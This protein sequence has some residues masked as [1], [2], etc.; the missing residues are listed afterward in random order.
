MKIRLYI[1]FLL[2]LLLGIGTLAAQNSNRLYIP[3]L[4]A[5]PG[6]TLS[7]PVY[8]ENSVEIVAVQFALQVPEGSTLTTASAA[9]ANR[10]DDHTVTLRATA[11]REYLCVIYSPT[12]SPIKGRTG[13]IMTVDMQVGSN[14]KEGNTY[15]F[16][17][18]DVIL[19]MRDGSNV[20]S[21]SEAGALTVAKRPDLSIKNVKADKTA[22][23][24]SETLSVSWQVQNVGGV[25]TGDGWSEQI[26]LVKTD[27][28]S[29]LLGTA[30]YDDTLSPSGIVSRQVTVT[31]PQVL[32]LD[33]NAK[34]QVQV[35]PRTGTGE[36]E[37][38]RGNNTAT[39]T[40]SVNVG[41]QL[42]LA[43]PTGSIV[44]NY[45]SPIRCTL[46]R[47][48]NR[49]QEQTFT[50]SSTADS[51][52]TIPQEVTIP[53]GQSAA[54]F[55]I[56]IK[57]NTTL[58]NSGL[59]N[60]TAMGNGY[61]AVSGQ[62]TIED[63]EYP[64]LKLV[65]S[66]SQ[67]TE[68]ES[69]QLT[70]TAS[71]VS[72]NPV[73]V[74]LTSENTN[75]FSFPTTVTIPSGKKSVQVAVQ[76]VDDELP[77]LDLSNAFTASAPGYNKGEVIVILK[78]N[79]LPV[80]ELTLTPAIVS[81]SAGVVAVAG[82]LK[83][84]TNTTS[85]IT[86]KLSDDA[87]GGLYFG[88]RTLEL[89][90]GVEEA[91]FNFGP[92]DN[93]LVDGDR[94]YTITAAVWLSSCSC[95]ASGE[96]AG[97]V[98]AQLQ[99]L[100]NDGAALSLTSSQSTVKEGGKTTL[101]VTRNTTDNTKP[102]TVTLQSDYDDNLTYNHTVTIPA[103]KTSATVEVTSKGNDIQGDSHTVVFTVQAN[104]Y[105]TGTCYLM[106][107]DQTLPD[108]RISSIT[109]DVTEAEV[110]TKV[111]LGI[112][113]ANDGAAV[114]P[115]EVPVKLYFRGDANAVGTIYTSEAI[116]VGG[117]QVL[118]KTITLP[119]TVGN[120]NY[121]AVVNETNKVQELTYNN[122]TSAD[123]AIATIAPFSASISTDKSVYS[124]GE[125]V[126]I[127]GQLTGNGTEN[128]SVDIYLINEGARQVQNVT[129]DANGS[130][131]YEWQLY[132][133]QSGHFSVGACYPG[134]GM[135]EEMASFDVYGLKRTDNGYITCEILVGETYNGTIEVE[136][137]CS[138]K[139]EDVH[140]ELLSEPSDCMISFEPIGKFEGGE[141][142]VLKYQIKGLAASD[143]NDWKTINA[144]MISNSGSSM[145]LTLYYYCR[146]PQAQLDAGISRIETTVVQ[147]S[148]REYPIT[149]TNRG[150]GESGQITLALPSFMSVQSAQPIPSLLPNESTTIML[151]LS[152]TDNMQLNVPVSNYI[153][154]NCENSNGVALPY[155]IVPVSESNGE[156]LVDVCD[157]YTYYT[158]EKPHVAGATL[159]IKR[160]LT[161]EVLY[162]GITESDGKY[163][164]ILP[165]G[166]YSLSV[167]ADK[168]ESYES[169][170]LIDPGRRNSIV[171][172]LS[173]EGGVSVNWDVVETEIEDEYTIS[174]T[175]T[176]ETN[177]P[178]P[179]MDLNIPNSIPANDLGIGESLIF[180]AT[181]TN[182]GL[183][184][185]H[186]AQIILPEDSPGLVFE[187]LQGA[188]VDLSAQQSIVIP[189]KVTRVD[190]S[191]S[192]R[193]RANRE[194][195]IHCV[196]VIIPTGYWDCGPDRKWYRRGGQSINLGIV[197][198]SIELSGDFGERSELPLY[199]RLSGANFN[200]YI[201]NI[202]EIFPP[203]NIK[204]DGCFPCLQSRVFDCVAGIIPFYDCI[205]VGDDCHDAQ[206]NKTGGW[207]SKTNCLLSATGC[208]LDV[209]A[210]ESLKTIV[211]TPVSAACE[212]AGI[213]IDII[214]CLVNLTE[215]C[216]LGEAP[217]SSRRKSSYE[218]PSFITA[219]REAAGVA[220]KEV[221]GFTDVMLEYFGDSVWVKNTTIE[222]QFEILT[223]F[224]VNTDEYFTI[225]GLSNY[226]PEGI[227]ESQLAML[228]ERLNNSTRYEQTGEESNNRI[229]QEFIDEGW[230]KVDEAEKEAI[231]MGYASVDEMF[232]IVFEDS[233]KKIVEKNSAV[234]ATISLQLDQTMTLTRQ[235]FRGTLT[236]YN[237]NEDTPMQDVKLNLK[238]TNMSTGEVSTSHEFQIN[239]E[240]L[241]GFSGELDLGS[242]WTLG[243][244][245]TG[246][247]TILFIPTKY[248]APTEPVEWSF[249]G[250]LNYID[251]FT[252]LEVTREL[253]PVTLTV[254]PTPELDLTYFMQRDVY[255]DDPLTEEV[256]P[257]VPAE[258]SLLINNIGNGDATNV[259]MMTNQPEI[260]EN[261]KGLAINFEILSAQLNGGD[262]TMALGGSVATDFG[263]IPAHSQA[264]AQ[265]WLQ[266]SL[267]GHFTEYDVRATH[268]TSY[269]N[270]DLSLLNDVTIHELIRSIKV[271]DG[272]VTGF[273]VND[274][275]DAEDMPDMVYFTDG[276]TAE[277]AA[278]A[279]ASCDR[280]SNTEFLLNVT[281]SQAGWNY[282]HVTDPTFGRSRLTGIRRQSDGK[283]INLRNFWQTDRTL[284]DGKEW[285][286]ENNLHFVDQMANSTETYVLTFEP[287]P[288][289]ELQV[290]SFGGVPE[291]NVVLHEPLQ[292]VTVTFNKAVNA[293]TFTSEDISLHCQG[294]PVEG[295]IGIKKVNDKQFKLDM[296]QLTVGNGYY[297]L[298]VQTAGITD[299]EGFNG[300][301]GKT[302]AWIQFTEPT[303]LALSFYEAE[304]T[305]GDNFTEPRLQ[306][307]NSLA[308]PSY[309]STNPLVASVNAETGHVTINAVGTTEVNVSV[310]KTAMSDAAQTSYSLTVLQPESF[311]EVPAGVETVSITIPEGQSM[312]TFCSPW[313][314]DFRGSKNNCKAY[315]AVTY[316]D[317]IVV[318]KEVNEVDGGVGLLI[319]GIPGTYTFPVSPTFHVPAENLFV[320]TLAPTYVDETTGDKTNLSLLA[321][322]FVPMS[323][324]VIGA[325]KA[326]LP[327][328]LDD[329]V[330]AMNIAL[331]SLT[332]LSVIT[333][334]PGDGAWY[335]VSGMKM[336]RPA[337]KGIYI[338]NGRK[339]IV[340]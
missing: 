175:I 164:Q 322:R 273:V 198:T 18:K 210:V 54:S 305:Y 63:N 297:V 105:A 190:F 275:V 69:F 288:D 39:T 263:T 182:R 5:L 58:D 236:V 36:S 231:A 16:V 103:G 254:K 153:G 132:A 79:D 234:C 158:D 45:A 319:I 178:V 260:I 119:Q 27:G 179:I 21:S 73:E 300:A 336:N 280:R 187:S 136:N 213:I 232:Q 283:E 95:G 96:S 43:L 8:V 144:R 7:V 145:P 52:L 314:I 205:S 23:A 308:V 329:G 77:S 307:N 227:T 9:L 207:R 206:T 212:T 253:F 115:A 149:I 225:G 24:P 51:R 172:N 284:R 216:N 61:D 196:E 33:G 224:A 228:V 261:E 276:T 312:I 310:E 99:V 199:G 270:P 287:R 316:R 140:V 302:A 243:A 183:I 131:Y 223:E 143:G 64:D 203:I 291:E 41:K 185:I 38:V 248:A 303:T 49:A 333:E 274:L 265:W 118:T 306:T 323:A 272:N 298:T 138:I 335:S 246:T 315:T 299:S 250:T 313:P 169:N 188:P 292:S 130:F 255:G 80:L 157:E 163:L 180:Y 156:L 84:T 108:A 160:L 56:Q 268:V 282:G 279:N 48:G 269:D 93:A 120:H 126:I 184:T 26:S 71:R 75:R 238:V 117:S 338:R 110:G 114:L 311:S 193:R 295:S 107:T 78:D 293:S 317:N 201:P 123:L 11:P 150:A 28:T 151:S 229:R 262:K 339:V 241:N 242:G 258:F 46:T 340:K 233:Y 44:E 226:K 220:L 222:E 296:N 2:C 102:L 59:I 327:V 128:T 148:S 66:K 240:S 277:V 176:Y 208:I 211:G 70:V 68:G 214:Q 32:G 267:L 83:R 35:I 252:G 104:G 1:P 181:L 278:A 133:L 168:H 116:P 94:T 113:V 97:H 174:T 137:P 266:S 101:T 194:T 166:Y 200:P 67:I 127:T 13:K 141:R 330:N 55:Y 325:N 159:K 10:A 29:V 195:Q 249:G 321:P 294:K 146:V 135:R 301:T 170:I 40:T 171:V 82:V 189:V 162:E 62:I 217:T 219:L 215:P 90:K 304:V 245:E 109:A 34:V 17:L 173:Y 204:H 154:L 3:E 122:N 76:T 134:E 256:E 139:Q 192:S 15:E 106:V 20:L 142:K 218:E 257:M 239:A 247:A 289:T 42:T 57:D 92:V 161:N 147:G 331:E 221:N 191:A 328:E 100:D 121:F 19:S 264:Y 89:A 50:L 230:N 125:K 237:G 14:Y 281:P 290:A 22:Y 85:K 31:L 155:T 167:S 165:E 235:A 25:V 326:Y 88:N 86:V 65:A 91:Y 244:N 318:C 60:V 129:T 81:E 37:G 124:Q 285:L 320:G 177:V 251:P 334:E 72:T 324:G 112:V 53:A 186:E 332:G 30:H 6:S 202:P 309:T 111:T 271:D 4:T 209:C 197:C 74:T 12:N 259:R 286:Y 87:E 47:S 337:G 98:T 152:C